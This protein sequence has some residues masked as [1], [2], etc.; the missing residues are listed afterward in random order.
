MPSSYR[1]H[2]H[3]PVWTRGH[4]LSPHETATRD[5]RRTPRAVRLVLVLFFGCF[6]PRAGCGTLSVQPTIG[7]V[8]LGGTGGGRGR[9]SVMLWITVAARFCL[10]LTLNY[11]NGIAF[12]ALGLA[13][14][15][16]FFA[17]LKLELSSPLLSSPL[18]SSPLLSSP[19]PC[20]RHAM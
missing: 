17:E 20:S 5:V 9:G 14:V 1:K 19:L 2:A 12:C 3:S 6:S 4:A 10:S 16:P 11:W 7:G 18:L 8:E 13:T 15:C